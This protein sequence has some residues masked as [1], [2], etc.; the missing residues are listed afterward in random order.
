MTN[1]KLGAAA[2]MCDKAI[3][4]NGDWTTILTTVSHAIGLDCVAVPAT[5]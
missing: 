5:V 3:H 4:F 2:Y 1:L